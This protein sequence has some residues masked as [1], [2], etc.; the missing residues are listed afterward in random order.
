MLFVG[1]VS[2]QVLMLKRA[3]SVRLVDVKHMKYTVSALMRVVVV[4]SLAPQVWARGTV[5]PA[6]VRAAVI[7]WHSCVTFA[8][9]AGCVAA[10]HT[11]KGAEP[12]EPA[13]AA[14]LHGHAGKESQAAEEPMSKHCSSS[15]TRPRDHA[16]AGAIVAT[17]SIANSNISAERIMPA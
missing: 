8:P 13:S 16:P 9:S 7:P 1:K 5:T 6:A 3:Y 10:R 2:A 17:S 4:G 11:K 15:A 14:R 12:Q